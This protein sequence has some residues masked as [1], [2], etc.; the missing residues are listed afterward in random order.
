MSGGPSTNPTEMRSNSPTVTPSTQPSPH[1]TVGPSRYPSTPPSLP[2][3][4]ASPT[5][6]ESLCDNGSDRQEIISYETFE[7]GSSDKW[8]NGWV[9]EHDPS[10][11]GFTKFLGRFRAGDAFPIRTFNFSPSY[12]RSL[13]ISF[14]F[15]ELDGWDGNGMG[16]VDSFGV[17]ISGDGLGETI[18]LG[19]YHH[20]FD[21]ES[22][23][24][25]SP[26]GLI[27]WKR[28]PE[29]RADSLALFGSFA[30][31]RHLITLDI[32]PAF[33]KV[34]GKVT[35]T[36]TF[37]LIGSV[38]EYVGIDN[39]LA[40]TCTI[41]V[42]TMAPSLNLSEQPSAKPSQNPSASPS[43]KPSV[44]PS[45][46][47]SARP[48]V[49]PSDLPTKQ[50]SSQPSG[51]P[52]AH[53]T[54][55]P[56]TKP[57][58]KPSAGPT[59][60]PSAQPS[61]KPSHGPSQSPSNLPSNMPS[62]RP[63]NMPSMKPSFKPSNTPSLSPPSMLPSLPPSRVPSVKP[64]PVPSSVPS[65]SRQPSPSLT[66]SPTKSL[67]AATTSPTTVSS[68]APS[69][70]VPCVN[71]PAATISTISFEDF[72]T[73][74]ATGWTNAKINSDEITSFTTFLGRFFVSDPDPSKTF[75]IPTSAQSMDVEFQFYELDTWDGAPSDT[76]EV[77]IIGDQTES[78]LIG[79]FKNNVD[80]LHSG[81]SLLGV[82]YSTTHG[83]YTDQG[84]G[85]GLCF[86][87]WDQKHDVSMQIPS[88]FFSSSGSV[89][90]EFHASGDEDQ[91]DFIGNESGG[92]DD[93]RIRSCSV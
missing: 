81:T 48:S 63:S 11:M 30:D 16:G 39:V 62:E 88:T 35:L 20:A 78:V 37:D 91:N 7:D 52:S 25:V 18:D 87:C 68:S 72:E 74:D 79:G 83:P 15:Y 92:I 21:E 40:R 27:S 1:P 24:G 58:S 65:E 61:F 84:F 47:P 38:D 3:P 77:T 67:I 41:T 54:Q 17:G 28:E 57:S 90:L 31:Q 14:H 76:L 5:F 23:E 73:G 10:N 19:H 2:F 71:N 44:E 12:V 93:L 34:S 82:T 64:S 43:L 55:S 13:T 26:S 4:S 56:S 22:I 70:F 49:H 50:P 8:T 66:T 80:D 75:T 51:V 33:F 36:I 89:T 29:S 46:N 6:S 53:P 42:P 85:G 86:T 45:E 69:V 59:Y 60:M 9:E 32:P